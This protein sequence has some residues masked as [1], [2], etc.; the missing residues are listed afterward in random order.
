MRPELLRHTLRLARKTT[1][2]WVTGIAA[3]LVINIAT[4]PAIEG[5]SGYDDLLDDM[6][7][8]MLAL[9]GIERGLSLTSPEG[10][11]I[12]QVFGFMLPLLL[13]ILAVTIGSRAVASEEEQHALDLLLAQPITRRR[14]YLEKLAAVAAVIVTVGASTWVVLAIACP[15]VGLDAGLADLAVATVADVLFALQS[16]TL[17][18]AVGAALGRRAPAAAIASVVALAGLVLESLAAVSDIVARVRWLGPFHFVNGNIPMLHGLRLLDIA[19]LLGLAVV[20]AVVGLL[21]FERRD[22]SA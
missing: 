21:V 10:F 15:I 17:A 18:L 12:S 14:L 4:W 16:G 3:F 19:V 13:V 22:L 20:A 5:Q 9:F 1:V 6:P 2:W 7:D 11:L 8:A